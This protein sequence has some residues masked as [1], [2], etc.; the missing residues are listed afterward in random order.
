ME[1]LSGNGKA[2]FSLEATSTG[3]DEGRM[4]TCQ[5]IRDAMPA[6]RI[7]PRANAALFHRPGP[8]FCVVTAGAA[9]CGSIFAR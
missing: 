7:T 3:G 9:A 2:I 8:A 5:M 6:T 4:K 1:G